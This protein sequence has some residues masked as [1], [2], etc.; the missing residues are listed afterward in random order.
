MKVKI[1]GITN[2][3]DA[4][5]ASELGADAVGFIFYKNSLR[6]L[7]YSKAKDI[8]DELPSSILKVGVFVNE[9]IDEINDVSEI[10]NLTNIQL[11]GEET[12]ETVNQIYLPVWKAFRVSTGFDF[13]RVKEFN[14]CRIMLDTYSADE[15]GG[16]GETFNWDLIPP[17]LKQDIILAGGISSNNI[18][19]IY[20]EVSP[21]W[22]DISSS[23]ELQPG[24]KDH[25]KVKEFFTII[26][27]LRKS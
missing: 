11:H 16:T 10:L 23:L 27:K 12:P 21:A 5:L 17:D 22:V 24:K 1:C 19:K 2:I 18:E 7:E 4:K 15:Y 26:N 8:I 25:K 3:E 6:Y 13:D 14:N 20:R 9:K